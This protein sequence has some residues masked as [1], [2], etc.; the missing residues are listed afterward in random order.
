MFENAKHYINGN[1]ASCL[2]FKYYISKL[3][4]RIQNNKKH[5]DVILEY[6]PILI[7]QLIMIPP[8]MLKLVKVWNRN[9]IISCVCM[10]LV[11]VVS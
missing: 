3:G 1:R 6:T 4:G 2:Q 11:P 9:C 8:K 7:G 5:S 10:T